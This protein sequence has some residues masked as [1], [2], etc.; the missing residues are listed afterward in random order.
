MSQATDTRRARDR[1]ADDRRLR[2]DCKDVCADRGERADVAP[3]AADAER[4]GEREHAAR[5]Q[6]DILARDGQ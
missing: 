6:H 3:H 2:P 1:G 4:D 5:E